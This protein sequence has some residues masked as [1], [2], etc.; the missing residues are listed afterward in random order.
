MPTFLSMA[1]IDDMENLQGY[2]LWP[3]L[4]NKTDRVQDYAI[5]E[6]RQS[7]SIITHEYKLG[8][9]PN[10]SAADF[11]DRREDPDE[12]NNLFNA[13]EYKEVID[14]LMNILVETR[15]WLKEMWPAVTDNE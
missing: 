8:I 15:P 9:Y 2:D 14:S 7:Y 1:G 6:I 5:N 13:P 3:M 11:Y 12:L 10:D 4:S